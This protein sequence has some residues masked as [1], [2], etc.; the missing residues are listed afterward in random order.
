MEYSVGQKQ[1]QQPSWKWWITVVASTGVTITVFG[2]LF[3]HITWQD[4]WTL[5]VSI[6]LRLL[7]VFVSLS[8]S[9]HLLRTVRYRLVLQSAGESVRF[10]MLFLAVLVRGF[11]VDILPAR[12]GELVYIYLLK[13][14][15]RV[16]LGAATASFILPFLFDVM[17]LGPM[18]MLAVFSV[19]LNAVPIPIFI[20][21][22][23]L[24]FLGAVIAVLMLPW[25]LRVAFRIAS[26]GHGLRRIRRFLASTHRQVCRARK[27]GIYGKIFALSVGVRF[28]KYSSLYVL[29]YALL[30]SDGVT[31][32]DLPPARAFLGFCAAEMAASLPISGL[33]GFGAYEGTWALVFR[34]LGFPES[35]AHVTAISH[36]LVTQAYGY[37]MGLVSLSLLM[38][39]TRRR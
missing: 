39:I 19:T 28:L 8:L 2:Y 12:T 33:A 3:T 1:K 17:V 38:V 22:G 23:F 36:H 20:A 11:C 5:L 15:L 27:A 29:L 34:L 16:D 14:R 31:L 21:A 6:D 24:L 9:Q 37:G 18:V 30:K 26:I 4:V 25:G 32:A 35:M 10:L 13:S 7:A